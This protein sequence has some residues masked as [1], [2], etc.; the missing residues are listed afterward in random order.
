MIKR[1][2][3]FVTEAQDEVVGIKSM[4]PDN[5]TEIKDEVKSMITKTVE[6]NGGEYKAFIDSFMQNPEDVKVEG[7]INDS[8]I[9][10]FYL[11]FRN[12]IDEILNNVKF[13]DTPATEINA[14]GLYEYVIEGTDRAFMEVIK[15]L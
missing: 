1:Y 14:Y 12:D 8:D 7:F 2:V 6:A 9:Y 11:K 10:E 13:F 3:E 5:Y 4:D 15:M